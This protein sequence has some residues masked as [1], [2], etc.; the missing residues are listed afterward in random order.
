MAVT[1]ARLAIVGARGRMGR[2]LCALAGETGFELV[3]SLDQGD[4]IDAGLKAADV[5]ID[6]SSHDVT[7]R[8]AACMAGMSRPVVIGTTGLDASEHEAVEAAAK[9]IPVVMAPN[10]SVGVNALFWLARRAA[11]ILGEGFDIEIVEMH[12]NQKK[13]APSGTAA[14]LAEILAV[15][16][17]LDAARDLRHGREGMPGARPR[18]EIGVHALRG[19]DVVGDHTVHFAAVG[20]RVEITHRASSRETFARGALRAA[21]WALGRPSGLYSMEDVLGLTE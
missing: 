21:R 15:A 2:T 3:A 6:F 10:F 7:P 11:A 14:R 16:R 1:G 18:G 4:D 9:S 8:V 5:A 13:D 20:E 12:H 19:G 17:G